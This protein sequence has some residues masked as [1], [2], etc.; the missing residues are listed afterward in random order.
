MKAKLTKGLIAAA[1]MAIAT[2]VSAEGELNIYNW[3]NYTNPKTIK[4]FEKEFD[5]KVTVTDYDSN[6]TAL[7]KIRA[8]GHGF[9]IV[10]PSANFVPIWIEEG[11]LLETRPDQMPNFKNVDAQWTD[12][13]FDPGRRYTV[14]W[15]WGTVGIIV[16][17]SL[18]S[19]DINTS[20]I[21]LNTP[22]E[23][24][25]KVSVVPEMADVMYLAIAHEGGEMCTDDLEVLKRVRD[26]LVE[27]KKD[28]ISMSYGSIES[29]VKGDIGAGVT[30]N[31]G[32]LRARLQNDDI[33]YGY[34]KEGYGIWVDNL[35]VLADAKNP[36]NAKL[37]QNYIMD[38]EVAASISAFSRHA[39]G[40]MGSEKF[41]PADMLDAPEVVIPQDLQPVGTLM[42]ICP[43]D[44]TKLYGAIWTELLK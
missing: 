8:G 20:D 3:G 32:A 2:S 15:Q 40:I 5:I 10:V 17:T 4:A 25:G 12:V 35:A 21:F 37:F 36:E 22:D 19:G 24:K 30:W 43:A 27:A 1:T 16:N 38:P 29:Y 39:N 18:Y 26:L 34:P 13:D 23:L 33:A 11:L 28:W 31:G 42:R 7:A 14:P 44:V 6:D 41:M 9:D